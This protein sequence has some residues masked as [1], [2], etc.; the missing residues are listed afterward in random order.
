MRMVPA[1]RAISE[2]MFFTARFAQEAKSAKKKSAAWQQR[3][4]SRQMPNSEG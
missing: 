1:L 3:D 4:D 2:R